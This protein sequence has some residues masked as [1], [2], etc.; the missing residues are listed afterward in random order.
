MVDAIKSSGPISHVI[1]LTRMLN[2]F[3][4]Q[5]TVATTGH[6]AEEGSSRHPKGIPKHALDPRFKFGPGFSA[7]DKNNI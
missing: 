7:E 4:E 2:E 3:R 6:L 5:G 1:E